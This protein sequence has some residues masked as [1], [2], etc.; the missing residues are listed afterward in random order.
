[1]KYQVRTLSLAI[2]ALS[3]ST[4]MGG[5]GTEATEDPNAPTSISED[6]TQPEATETLPED[7]IKRGNAELFGAALTDDAEFVAFDDLIANPDGY[8]DRTIQTEGI[9]RN[10]CQRRGCWMELR[11]LTESDSESITVKFLNYG[12]FVPLDSRGA[13]ARIEGIAAAQTLSAEEVEELIAEG[14]DPGIL[15]EDGTATMVTFIASGVEMW[16]RNE[17]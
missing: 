10:V 14:Y 5:C 7:A 1:M 8:V 3:F 11:S 12:F 6:A 2:V 15:N 9:S 17:D 13:I 16:N 4:T